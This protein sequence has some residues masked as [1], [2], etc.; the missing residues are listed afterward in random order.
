M[1]RRRLLVAAGIVVAAVAL[2]FAV[3]RGR[4]PSDDLG[5]LQGDW[6]ITAE[7]RGEVGRVRI[8]GDRWTYV[9]GGQERS[10]HRVTLDP[11]A[12]PKEID[13]TALEP[14]GTPRRFTSGPGKGNE[15]KQL[16]VYAL[17]RD[18]FAVA[19]APVQEG[20]RPKSLDADLP[21][22][23]MTRLTK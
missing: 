1:T 20:R 11:T 5:R 4:G 22:L 9:S 2:W 7:G 18:T 6:A 23:T 12:T 8:D 15:V 10:A 13:L 3:L 17:D 19:L 16:G 14:Y 21:L